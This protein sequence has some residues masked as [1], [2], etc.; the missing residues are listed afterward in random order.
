MSST[1]KLKS[2]SE[3]IYENRQPFKNLNRSG[4]LPNVPIKAEILAME[5]LEENLATNMNKFVY[6]VQVK[7]G[8]YEWVMHKVFKDFFDLYTS[9]KLSLVTQNHSKDEENHPQKS[10]ASNVSFLALPRALEP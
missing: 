2:F 1:C 9:I 7:H 8:S 6:S 3:A 4:F 10:S 5:K